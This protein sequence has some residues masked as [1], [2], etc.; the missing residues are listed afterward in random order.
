MPMALKR[1]PVQ[2]LRHS[3][4]HANIP[5]DHALESMAAMQRDFDAGYPEPS[6]SFTWWIG[7]TYAGNFGPERSLRLNPFATF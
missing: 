7:D 3:I 6:P 1:K 2:G 5:S 4:I